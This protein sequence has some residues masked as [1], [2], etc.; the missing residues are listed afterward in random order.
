M[1]RPRIIPVLL[2]RGQGLVKSI[3]FN[4]FRYIGDPINAV[5]IFNDLTADELV[6]LD[7]N[8][9]KENRCISLEF[10]SK[11]GSQANMPFAVGGG[12]KTV[13]QI[14]NIIY[15]GAE[16]VIINSAAFSDPKFVKESVCEFGSSTITVSIDVKKNFLN[17][18]KVFV[19][20]GSKN[21]KL[22][23]IT[24][25]KMI[26]DM[27]VGEIILNSV[28]KDGLMEGYDIGLIEKVSSSVTVPLVAVGGAGNYLD[29][30][31]AVNEGKAS[32]VGAGSM[33]VYHGKRNAVLIN[34]P[35]Q[36]EIVNMFLL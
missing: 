20:G 31:K 1:F 13:E 25:A 9:H 17:D 12:I 28:N 32:A 21:T 2:L 3:R 36:D 8:A 14:R 16:K 27:G 34:Y 23:P 4:K 29:F 33:F 11:V 10:V 5:K 15:A 26:E 19:K 35:S 24:Y 18:Y 6:F 30:Q 7:I 22:D